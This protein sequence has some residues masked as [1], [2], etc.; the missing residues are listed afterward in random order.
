MNERLRQRQGRPRGAPGR[1]RRLHGGVQALTGQGGWPMTVFA[2]A[3]RRA[4]LRR[5]VLPAAPRA[6]A[7]VVRASCS[8][9]IAQTWRERPRRASS[10][11]AQPDRASSSR[12]ER[13]RRP[14]PT[15]QP[16]DRRATWPLP[17]TALGRPV[18]PRARRVRRRAEVPAV[19]GAG[20]A[21][22]PPRPH[23][24]TP[25]RSRWSSGTLRGDGARR[26]V[27]PAR[28]RLRPLLR[29]RRL[30]RAALR[31]DAVRQRFAA[32]R[33]RRTGGGRPGSPLAER[34]VRRDRRRSCCATCAR[35]EGG[36]AS[37][38][39]ADTDGVE[40]L[41][42]VWTPAAADRRARR[43][44]R[45][46]GPPSCSASPPR[47]R[48]STARRRCSCRA[49][50]GRRRR[51]GT[52]CARPAARGARAGAPQPARDDKVVAAWNGLAVA[53]L[54]EAGALLGRAGRGSRP[55]VAC[56]RPARSRAPRARARAG[57]VRASRATASPGGTP[58]CSRTTRDV[59]EG[60]LALLRR[61]RRA[62]WLAQ[63]RRAARRRARRTSATATAAST[64]PP[65]TPSRCSRRPQDPTDNATPSGTSAAAGALLTYAALTGSEPAPRGRR[66]GARP[67]TR[68]WRGGT[69]G[70]PAGGSRWP[71]RWLD[72]PREV[73]VV[74]DPADAGDRARCAGSA[75]RGTAPG[76]VRRGRR[77][78]RRPA[79]VAAARRT[80]RCVGGRPAAYVCRGFVCDA[81][82]TDPAALAAGPRAAAERHLGC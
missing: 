41:T 28:R 77:P 78:G 27:R 36:F 82:T 23:R 62:R 66:G 49:R 7:A 24:S 31:E 3:R 79:A 21:A 15:A 14:R 74:G 20:A 33:L 35:R 26:H 1:R 72:G 16:P 67:S 58:A 45:P 64:T 11:G 54:A 44:R 37:A 60:L 43:R 34:V 19:D 17:S 53:A 81:P 47:A 57:C 55:R 38:L 50:P 52:A 32:P 48:S 29:R 5:H 30:G 10:D 63:R 18:R 46:R 22:A 6:R 70:S 76:L 9:A 4:V 2:H 68:R 80:G 73:A 40:G 25:T 61:H 69:R 8:T 12:T 51:A 39:D 56:G 13:A 71:R 65:T 59:A 75:R 42:Y